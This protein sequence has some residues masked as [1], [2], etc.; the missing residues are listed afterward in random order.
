MGVRLTGLL[1]AIVLGLPLCSAA[2]APSIEYDVKAAFLLNFARFVEWP[3]AR[4][5]V[6]FTLCTLLPDPFGPRLEA[7]TLGE[8]WEGRSIVIRR[9]ATPREV[10][11]HLLYVPAQANETFRANLA[12]IARQ[13]TLLVG[14]TRDFVRQGGMIELFIDANRVRFSVN[15]KL[16]EAAGLHIGSRLLRLAR[17]VVSR[18]EGLQ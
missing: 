12:Q 14:E 15:Q 18:S 1:I 3:E 10:D 8:T 5:T 6:P 11:C 17:D 9:I 16:A 2:Q 4:R 13:P 7:A